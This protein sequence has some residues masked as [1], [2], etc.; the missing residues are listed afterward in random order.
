M[1]HHPRIKI[2]FKIPAL[3][4]FL[5]YWPPTSCKIS[6]KLMGSRGPLIC[7]DRMLFF[8]NINFSQQFCAWLCFTL[9]FCFKKIDITS[10]TYH[11]LTCISSHTLLVSLQLTKNYIELIAAN[12]FFHFLPFMQ[13]NLYTSLK[14]EKF[15]STIFSLSL[16]LMFWILLYYSIIFYYSRTCLKRTPAVPNILSALDRCP[17]YRGSLR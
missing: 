10:W 1:T 9:V 11:F 12:K 7:R 4:L 6:E 15:C 17:L 2:F 13:M 3:S 8:Y 14:Q 5:L 16:I